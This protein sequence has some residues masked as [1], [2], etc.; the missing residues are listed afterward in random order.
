MGRT[1]N[2]GTEFK[3]VDLTD[4][5]NKVKHVPDNFI[6]KDGCNI[7]SNYVDYVLP[8]LEGQTELKYEHGLPRFANLKKV[9]IDTE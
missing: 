5:A 4:V 1:L 3:L 8:L 6:T 9:L 7:K 2:D